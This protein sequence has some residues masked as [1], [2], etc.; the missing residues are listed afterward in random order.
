ML[1]SQSAAGAYGGA[2]GDGIWMKTPRWW[3]HLISRAQ[4]LFLTS[5]LTTSNDMQI[6]GTLWTDGCSSVCVAPPPQIWRVMLAC[7]PDGYFSKWYFWLGTK[8]VRGLHGTFRNI[9]FL[10][11]SPRS[12]F[13]RQLRVNI[14]GTP[15][16]SR[17]LDVILI[18]TAPAPSD[19]VSRRASIDRT[20]T[21]YK[22]VFTGEC[23]CEWSHVFTGQ[24][25]DWQTR[26]VCAFVCG[27]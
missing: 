17:L 2:S 5:T 12:V 27:F 18:P 13:I 23:E 19:R 7:R 24:L 3:N 8:A 15:A 9:H 1:Q 14:H 25:R 4:A 11:L 21:L 26:F 10:F 22:V 20:G 6:C 16:K